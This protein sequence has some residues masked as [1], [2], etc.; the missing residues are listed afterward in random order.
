MCGLDLDR[1]KI[2]LDC[3]CG[4]TGTSTIGELLSGC[5]FVDGLI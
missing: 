3:D 1:E 2:A 5:A 4:A